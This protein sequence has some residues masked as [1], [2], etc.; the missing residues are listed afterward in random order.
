MQVPSLFFDATRACSIRRSNYE[1][2]TLE[3]RITRWQRTGVAA[4]LLVCISTERMIH[5]S[6]S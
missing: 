2:A 5:W 1:G 3:I 6:A 4:M